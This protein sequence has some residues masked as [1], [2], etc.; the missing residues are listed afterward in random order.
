[1]T[2]APTSGSGRQRGRPETEDGLPW[3]LVT[4]GSRGIG[5][6]VVL[7][8]ATRGWNVALGFLRNEEAAEEVASAVRAL[9]RKVLLCPYNL[10][11]V[12]ERNS[13]HL[14]SRIQRTRCAPWKSPRNVF[15]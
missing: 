1:M 13:S 9:D 10:V 8:L 6:A 3:A 7:D 11:K 2:L 5:R 15:V 4:G 14:L 12:D